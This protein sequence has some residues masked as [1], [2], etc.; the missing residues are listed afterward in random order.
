MTWDGRTADGARA[1]EGLY[2]VRVSLRRG[3]R[4]V[5]LKPGVS[6]DVV[7]PRPTVLAGGPDGSAGSPARSAAS[8]AVPRAGRLAALPHPRPRLPHRRGEPR[9]GRRF[10]LPPGEREGE[11]DGTADGAPAPPGTYQIV[12]AV[13]DQAG[14]VGLLRAGGPRDRARRRRA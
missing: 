11:W 2:R 8:G 7:A 5:D 1:P 9:D 3:G 4:A 13:R 12:A 10:T 14:N 6:L